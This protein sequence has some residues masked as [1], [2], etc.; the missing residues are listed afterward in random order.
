MRRRCYTPTDTNYKFYGARGISV[1]EDWGRFEPFREWAYQNGYF[2][3]ERGKCTLDRIDPNGNYEPLNCRWISQKE[4]VNNTRRNVFLSYNGETL[5]IKQWAEKLG[6]CYGTLQWRY[7][8]GWKVE[9]ILSQENHKTNIK[10]LK[11]RA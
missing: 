8:K 1:C 4:Q 7:Q 3:A 6:I 2:E 11:K 5:T 10:P 9:Q